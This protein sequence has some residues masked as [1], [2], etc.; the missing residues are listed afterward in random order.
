[1]T[2]NMW[3]VSNHCNLYTTHMMQVTR[4]QPYICRRRDP[5]PHPQLLRK[6]TARC[7]SSSCVLETGTGCLCSGEAEA[8]ALHKRGSIQARAGCSEGSSYCGGHHTE[9]NAP[10]HKS[11]LRTRKVVRFWH[12]YVFHTAADLSG[13]VS[14]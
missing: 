1:M 5:S 8:K 14:F 13:R 7:I 3:R 10:L 12:L 9:R 4:R 11:S 2:C 6:R